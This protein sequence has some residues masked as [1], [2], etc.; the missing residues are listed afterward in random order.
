MQCE[1]DVLA[2]HQAEARED[3]E[4]SGCLGPEL[5]LRAVDA[6]PRR[7]D[8]VE[9]GT[10]DARQR[11]GIEELLILVVVVEGRHVEHGVPVPEFRLQPELVGGELLR[12]GEGEL[13]RIVVGLA[14]EGHP[15][16]ALADARVGEQALTWLPVE[17]DLAADVIR[18]LAEFG[19]HPLR[20][21]RDARLEEGIGCWRGADGLRPPGRRV[22]V[23][24]G[25]G[26]RSGRPGARKPALERIE[27][28]DRHLVLGVAQPR[29]QGDRWSQG[30]GRIEEHGP[31]VLE[32][33]EIV[34]LVEAVQRRRGRAGR[35]D[36]GARVA[37]EEMKLHGRVHA[38]ARVVESA[39]PAKGTGVVGS[40]ADLLGEGIDAREVG[41]RVVEAHEDRQAAVVALLV[42]PPVV[43]AGHGSQR[44]LRAQ[45]P[46]DLE[47]G[48]VAADVLV[49]GELGAVVEPAD[50]AG[51][52]RR[53][54]IVRA[55]IAR[56]GVD[57]VRAVGRA[58]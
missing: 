17:A 1:F 47:R 3:L 48:V 45:L 31:A 29:A 16:V 37:V 12:I 52:V 2:A 6:R 9:Q 50:V 14:V 5:E 49:D 26:G 28:A 20:L 34:V 27:V 13:T 22:D 51:E 40:D 39:E 8:S 23:G 46:V 56:I 53:G 18:V 36:E 4:V 54:R 42:P 32:L 19:Y 41:V 58:A 38:L 10:A 7:I 57:C 43:I 35:R 33:V 11:E 44:R 25:A 30:I 55:R 15:A 24:I 21:R